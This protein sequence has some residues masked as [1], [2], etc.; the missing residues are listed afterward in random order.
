[1]TLPKADAP[2]D[3]A[4]RVDKFCGSCHV[5]PD[6]AAFPKSSW[7][8]EV[9]RGFEFYFDSGRTD[10][11]PPSQLEVAEYFRSQAPEELVLSSS[12]DFDKTPSPLT[13]RR[14][15]VLSQGE[16]PA[17]NYPAS[18]SFIDWSVSD[19]NGAFWLSDMEHATLTRQDR[20]G[21][22]NWERVGLCTNPAAVRTCDLN[23][24]GEPDLVATDLGSAQS[25][26]HDRGRVFWI[27]D[28]G[29]PDAEP[30]A[31]LHGAGRVADVRVGDFD[32]DSRPD[33]VVAEFGWHRTGGI[34]ILFNRS[35]EA[36]EGAIRFEKKTIDTRPGAIH[37]PP[38]DLNGDGRLDLV[39]IISQEHEIVVAFL[40]EP[41]GF[42]CIPL[43]AAHDPAH[44]S[45]GIELID[46][47]A[48]DD[49]DVLVTNGDS[50]DTHLIKPFHGIYWLENQG[51]LSFK[52]RPLTK[53]PGVFRAIAV[54]LDRDG[55]LDIAAAALLPFSLL[56]GQD[57]SQFDSIVWLE[58]TSKG[59][60]ERHAIERGALAHAGMTIAD[61][62]ADGDL[63]L[64]VGQFRNEDVA[65]GTAM[66]IFWNEGPTEIANGDEHPSSEASEN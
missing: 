54:D 14:E 45:S 32:G 27:P 44:G 65:R 46:L 48:D 41:D 25:A 10:L 8:D 18:I 61:F 13:F 51:D 33:L 37:V 62:D 42:R 23:A 47:D 52:E 31:V 43:S 12:T 11:D 9:R 66:T 55:D 6:P 34:H 3:L 63:D 16:R 7:H 22:V 56:R 49:L 21:T 39:A 1:M 60:F 38:A 50:F 36:A 2:R 19:E 15:D 57:P 5:V 29:R 53:L 40:N 20:F 28:F 59:H 64:A 4:Q 24:N 30:R 26:D 58:Q 17:P 35:D